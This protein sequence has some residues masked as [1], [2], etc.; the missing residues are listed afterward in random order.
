MHY[1]SWIW[2]QIW[3]RF[4]IWQKDPDP[5]KRSRSYQIRI[6]NTD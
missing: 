6:P 3:R 1:Q 5:A 2:I 4:Q